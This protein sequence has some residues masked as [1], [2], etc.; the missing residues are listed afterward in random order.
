MKDNK[1]TFCNRRF[2]HGNVCR[3]DMRHYYDRTQLGMFGLNTTVVCD[4]PAS[5]YTN[6][7]IL[8]TYNV[9]K[10]D[11]RHGATTTLVDT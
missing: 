8:K 10:C 5:D 9:R 2:S 11:W 6:Q 7:A 3:T 1:I 4:V